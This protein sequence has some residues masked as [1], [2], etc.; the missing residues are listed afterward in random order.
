MTDAVK[1]LPTKEQLEAFENEIAEIY[2]RGLIQAPVHLR[3]LEDR[4]MQLSIVFL[5]GREF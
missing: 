4:G 3:C 1:T 5:Q 2:S